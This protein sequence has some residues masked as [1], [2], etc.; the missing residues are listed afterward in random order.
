E[1][2]RNGDPW[3]IFDDPFNILSG[4]SE[5]EDHEDR[6]VRPSFVDESEDTLHA[7]DQ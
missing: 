5:A 7:H 3:R 1:D 4:Q 6:P 2:E